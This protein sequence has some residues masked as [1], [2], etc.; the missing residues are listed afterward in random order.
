M[1]EYS[2]LGEK[3]ELNTVSTSNK[4]N[5]RRF[6]LYGNWVDVV[7]DDR[8]P[9]N[10]NRKLVFMHSTEGHEFWSALLEKAYAKFYGSY[11]F[12]RGGHTSEAQEDFTGGVGEIYYSK[13]IPQNFFTTLSNTF[14][15]HALIGCSIDASPSE[16][17][18]LTPQ[19]DIFQ[20]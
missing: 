18:A 10:R 13:N 16:F 19:G 12:L 11:E 15:K 4:K 5:L 8:L 7:V 17:E 20:T 1:P 9:T 6:W 3:C 14:D 2:T